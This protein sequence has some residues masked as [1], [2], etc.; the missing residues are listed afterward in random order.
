MPPAEPQDGPTVEIALA[1]Y[2]AG[3]WLDPLLESLAT[4]DF[5][6]WRVLVRDDGSTDETPRRLSEWQNRLGER[7]AIV[8]G[9][10][11]R[12]LGATG[13][14]NA[15]LEASA[16]PWVMMADQDDI[17]MPR[18]IS[19]TLT[20]MRQAESKFGAGT[21][22][23]VFTDAEVMDGASVMIA[24]SYWRWNHI[25]L[26][27][28]NDLRR[29]AMDS[30]ALGCTMMVNRALLDVAL[31]IAGDVP[32]HDW[33]LGMAAAAFGRLIPLH[34]ATIRYRRH[35]GNVTSD[36]YLGGAAVAR[37]LRSPVVPR[38]RLQRLI[39]QTAAQSRAFVDRY[40]EQLRP[41]D[42]AAL[43]CLAGL[44]SRGPLERRLAIF[45]HGLWFSSR[46]K[47][48]GLVALL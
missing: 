5:A 47:N 25:K 35:G 26:D 32:Y 31:P 20:A 23:A 10:G 12:N 36:P 44:P 1:T 13:N 43:D 28:L 41:R 19:R 14:F 37:I 8:P 2:N 39:G 17:W 27:R 40:R 15:A 18:K 38:Q 16:A 24:P 33:W 3:P 7:F 42:F 29:I 45:R 22:L 9:S 30:P 11:A 4:Q 46:L 6:A 34:E 21:P 48:L